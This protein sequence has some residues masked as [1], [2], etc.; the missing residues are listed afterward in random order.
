MPSLYLHRFS[1][2]FT[3]VTLLS[4]SLP[5]PLYAQDSS[6]EFTEATVDSIQAAFKS[7][8]LT[9][10][11]LVQHYLSMIQNLNPLLR[12]VIEVN[13]DAMTQAAKADLER[14]RYPYNRNRLHGIP[15]LLKDNIGT[16]DKLNT[17]AGS[18]ALLGSVVSR[19]SG[20][21]TRL[22]KIGAVILGKASMSEWAY[23][24]SETAP[25]GW[26]ARSGKGINPYVASASPCGSS[27]GSAIAAAA[28]M[29]NMV[30]VTLGTETDGSIICPAVA[31]SVVGIK[32]TVGLTSR[33][34]VIPISPR[35]DTIGPICRTVRDAVYVLDA[36]VGYDVYDSPATKEAAK[37]IPK[38][39]YR[40]FLNFDG[41]RGKKIGILREGFF[42]FSKNSVQA[43]VFEQHFSL[44]RKKGAVLIDNLQIANTSVILDYNQ[45]GEELALVSEFKVALNYY[46]SQL[47]SSPVRS[48]AD[49][50]SFNENHKKEERIQEYGQLIFLE[51]EST[52]GINSTVRNAI[53]NMAQLSSK[54]IETLMKEK[55]LD[56]I[57][58][59]NAALG[60]ILAI[61]GYP[62]ISVPAG[63]DEK[64]VPFGIS[65]GGLKGFEPRLIE[66]AYAFEQ[67]TKVRKPP[68]FKDN[69]QIV[70]DL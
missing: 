45:S 3:L 56:T 50:I 52:K 12:A 15:I 70:S 51:S 20:V 64:G 68:S 25:S 14:R 8:S 5:F 24:R 18:F 30:T 67:A 21:V 36:I 11:Q 42:N 34:M 53:S 6:F 54:G 23:F 4:L 65:F 57:V 60:P 41:L 61:G 22:R 13:P 27:S 39:G 49:V 16:A 31:N 7:G 66:I 17:T 44:M 43:K 28:N 59:E 62:G 9:S 29:V 40:R 37:Y 63:Y 1:F 33:S 2:S 46:L 32:P 47:T 58:T 26:C 55:H 69:F 38:G 35:Q 10:V 48:L 19:D